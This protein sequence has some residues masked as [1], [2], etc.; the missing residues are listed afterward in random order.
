MATSCSA[1]CLTFAIAIPILVGLSYLFGGLIGDGTLVGVLVFIGVYLL[2]VWR[3]ITQAE[4]GA[5][6]WRCPHCRV[7]VRDQHATVC[8]RCGYTLRPS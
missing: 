3:M 2:I 4:S 7:R 6:L 1:G 8:R 5:F